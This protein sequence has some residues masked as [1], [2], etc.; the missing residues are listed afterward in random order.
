MIGWVRKT[1]V[2]KPSGVTSLMLVLAIGLVLTVMVG[3]ITALTIREQQ[4]ASNTELSN[5]AL[6]TAEAGVD[7]AVQLLAKN[8][9]YSKT[10]CEPGND[11]GNVV[12]DPN[13]QITCIEV[14]SLF[15]N[16]EGYLE[17]DRTSTFLLNSPLCD[18][19][20]DINAGC[21]NTSANSLMVR[22]NS[23]ADVKNNFSCSADNSCFYASSAGYNHAA[24]M[25]LSFIYWPKNNPANMSTAT[26]FVMPGSDD[27]GF[28]ATNNRTPVKSR[29]DDQ[30]GFDKSWLGDY[31]CATTNSDKGFNIQN[32][33]GISGDINSYTIAIRIT[34]RYTNTHYQLAAYNLNGDQVLLKATKAQIDVT[35]KVS[36]LYRRVKAEKVII[37]GSVE[38]VFDSAL[39]SGKGVDD[40]GSKDICKSFKVNADGSLIDG[41]NQCR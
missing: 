37:P 25:E 23:S 1:F 39:Y 33:L 35:A 29:C 27:K 24:G 20:G 6:Q 12:S 30:S 32:S 26:V 40:M 18:P 22:W 4:K 21:T 2:N 34:P 11:F 16:F 28:S 9:N 17:R 8:P 41:S 5:R 31:K 15:N 14:K 19:N 36:N 10:G 38:S 13:Q 7:A 3:G